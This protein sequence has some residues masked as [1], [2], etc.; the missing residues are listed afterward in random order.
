MYRLPVLAPQIWEYWGYCGDIESL[1]MMTFPDTGRFRG[2]VFI[3]FV[4]VRQQGGE[5]T[6]A[7]GWGSSWSWGGN[8]TT[9]Q[10]SGWHSLLPCACPPAP[11][12][13]EEGYEAALK[14]DG[15]DCDGQ[16]L[17]VMKCRPSAKDRQQMQQQRAQQ[18][19]PQAQAQAPPQ[20][21]RFA[22][23]AQY[24]PAPA[25]QAQ[26]QAERPAWWQQREDAQQGQQGAAAG[27]PRKQ[28]SGPAP[29]T[30][31]YHV[32]YV[33][34][35]LLAFQHADQTDQAQSLP[36]LPCCRAPHSARLTVSAA[37]TA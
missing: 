18:A 29:K 24:E 36:C 31:G 21:P 22:P 19:P 33:G 27:P 32:A 11:V 34:E 12:V 10:W 16:T 17:K 8:L 13:Q 26:Q 25:Q 1:D 6:E 37:I 9:D 30:P 3:T 15:E 5:G 2:I 35:C 20:Q 23:P 4:K 7:G 28:H 14:C